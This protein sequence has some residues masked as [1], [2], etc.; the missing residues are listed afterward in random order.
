M[1]FFKEFK[2]Y[3]FFSG[4][5]HYGQENLFCGFQILTENF[6]DNTMHEICIYRKYIYRVYSEMINRTLLKLT[7]TRQVVFLYNNNKK[8]PQYLYMIFLF[9]KFPSGV[10]GVSFINDPNFQIYD[11][12]NR[13]NILGNI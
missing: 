6:I 3:A 8:I 13:N 9:C 5:L 7:I 1:F 10:A 11:R 2:M 4:G 12:H